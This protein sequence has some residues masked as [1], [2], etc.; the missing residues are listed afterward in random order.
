MGRATV[1]CVLP[2]KRCL[3]SRLREPS[4]KQDE[5]RRPTLVIAAA[6]TYYRAS[7]ERSEGLGTSQVSPPTIV[8]LELVSVLQRLTGLAPVRLQLRLILGDFPGDVAHNRLEDVDVTA[9]LGNL[10]QK[11]WETV[12]YLAHT[13]GRGGTG[14]RKSGWTFDHPNMEAATREACLEQGRPRDLQHRI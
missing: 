13:T 5:R 14:G 12:R 3:D 6:T 2:T 1:S 7:F 10:R 8:T 4:I 11:V 9:V